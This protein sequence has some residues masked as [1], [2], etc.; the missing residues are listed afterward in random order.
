MIDNSCSFV[1]KVMML[2]LAADFL[3]SVTLNPSGDIRNISE[4]CRDVFL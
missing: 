1:G 3:N 2:G 4:I